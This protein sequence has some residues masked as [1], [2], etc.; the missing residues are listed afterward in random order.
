MT[1]QELSVLAQEHEQIYQFPRFSRAEVWELGCDI[2]EA[3]KKI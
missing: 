3:C 1:G 2:V